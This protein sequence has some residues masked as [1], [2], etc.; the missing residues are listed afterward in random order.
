MQLATY[1]ANEFF[2]NN[3]FED[4]VAFSGIPYLL[5]EKKTFS[6]LAHSLAVFDM[7][8]GILMFN[9]DIKRLLPTI[10]AFDE[11]KNCKISHIEQPVFTRSY[12]DRQKLSMESE[13][14]QVAQ[15]TT[16]FNSNFIGEKFIFS[17]IFYLYSIQFHSDLD[18]YYLSIRGYEE[19]I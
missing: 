3:N 9:G 19:P 5:E 12:I 18:K 6:S 16:E 2:Y 13:I 14:V 8:D 7:G 15:Y 1:K 11:F 4:Y 10:N 17:G